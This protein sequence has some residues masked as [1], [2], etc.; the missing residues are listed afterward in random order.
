MGPEA[1]DRD[2]G[3]S[4]VGAAIPVEFSGVYNISKRARPGS[5]RWKRA[6]GARGPKNARIT[7]NGGERKPED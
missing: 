2:E 1:A 4:W 6:R 5:L 3:T 7:K